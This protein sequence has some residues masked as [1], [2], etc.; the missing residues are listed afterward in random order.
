MCREGFWKVKCFFKW[1]IIRSNGTKWIGGRIKITKME[2][3]DC[4]DWQ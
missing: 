2:Y 3:K 4:N 1:L